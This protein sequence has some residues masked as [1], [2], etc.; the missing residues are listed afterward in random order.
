MT[1]VSFLWQFI[2]FLSRSEFWNVL[3][4]IAKRNG[5]L[6]LRASYNV[7]DSFLVRQGCAL[8]E[9]ASVRVSSWDQINFRWAFIN[10]YSIITHLVS[11]RFWMRVA[12]SNMRIRWLR[13]SNCSFRHPGRCLILPSA[14]FSPLHP[15]PTSALIRP[16][17]A[18]HPF[19][20]TQTHARAHRVV[21][22]SL[23]EIAD[24]WWL[25]FSRYPATNSVATIP[26]SQA[27]Q[28]VEQVLQQL[29]VPVCCCTLNVWQAGRV[30]QIVIHRRLRNWKEV[31][32]N[33]RTGTT[34]KAFIGEG[35]GMV[36][37]V[38]RNW[39]EVG[40]WGLR[41]GE[42]NYL[43]PSTITLTGATSSSQ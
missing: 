12:F 19:V 27:D 5:H 20:P 31:L 33:Y 40:W 6:L 1:V 18:T 15:S 10:N 28:R 36:S 23:R 11:T 24:L 42:E 37:G 14:S 35:Q 17:S 9:Y 22:S 16:L 25:I 21:H 8:T 39:S 13:D 29:P 34:E 4:K 3:K 30:L 41:G 2:S 26:M 38:E 32:A 7:V 43:K